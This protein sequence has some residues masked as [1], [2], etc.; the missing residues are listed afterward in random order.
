MNGKCCF[1]IV[2]LPIRFHPLIHRCMYVCAVSYHRIY[3]MFPTL[4]QKKTSP[5]QS[6][7]S[8]FSIS[9]SG[10]TSPRYAT[11]ITFVGHKPLAPKE[12]KA[13]CKGEIREMLPP[14]PSEG[15]SAEIS[16][17]EIKRPSCVSKAQPPDQRDSLGLI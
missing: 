4:K 11:L 5:L 6:V 8:A 10:Q 9:S 13:H 12:T 15:R 14:L 7:T 16:E 3:P 17:P 2:T 1:N